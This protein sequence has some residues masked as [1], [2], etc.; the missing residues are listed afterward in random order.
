MLADPVVCKAA[1]VP[2][3]PLTRRA[4]RMQDGNLHGLVL[5]VPNMSVAFTIP[6]KTTTFKEKF[7][8]KPSKQPATR[9][10][11]E[12][13]MFAEHAAY[14][15]RSVLSVSCVQQKRG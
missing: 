3:F 13:S 7:A 14:Q 12:E 8:G 9:V 11:E 6:L 5:D 1:Q 2:S 10:V 15:G 4:E